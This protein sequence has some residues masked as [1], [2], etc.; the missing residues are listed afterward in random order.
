MFYYLFFLHIYFLATFWLRDYRDTV[1]APTML[2]RAAT[3]LY[4]AASPVLVGIMQKNHCV[5]GWIKSMLD[6]FM[7]CRQQQDQGN[8]RGSWQLAQRHW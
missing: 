1:L 5:A 6:G 2:G 4:Y 7:H 8:V 3:R